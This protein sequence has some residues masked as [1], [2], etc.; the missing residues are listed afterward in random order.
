MGMGFQGGGKT[1]RRYQPVKSNVTV[2][3]QTETRNE[4]VNDVKAQALASVEATAQVVS[5]VNN[6]NQQAIAQAQAATGGGGGEPDPIVQGLPGQGTVN[7]NGVLKTTA[8][9]LNSNNNFMR[10]L[11]K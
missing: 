2:T 8:T 3:H 1:N 6:Q 4:S 10:G 11:L 7:I 9:S 5:Q